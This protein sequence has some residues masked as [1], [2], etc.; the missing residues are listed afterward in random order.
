MKNKR[1]KRF[2]TGG[3]ARQAFVANG[4]SIAH[5]AKRHGV[6]VKLVYAVL[7]GGHGRANR[8]GQSHKIAV[9]LGMKDGVILDAPSAEP[10]FTAYAAALAD[11][12]R[13][14]A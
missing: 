2:L 12:E 10:D 5:W 8:Y 9:L 13:E 4:V 6:S 14:A 3:E 7:A 11:G 1:T